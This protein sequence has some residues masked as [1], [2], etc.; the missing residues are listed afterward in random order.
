MNDT[1]FIICC[2]LTH[3]DPPYPSCEPSHEDQQ[4]KVRLVNSAPGL[5]SLSKQ[6]SDLEHL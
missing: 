1:T 2:P 5:Q 3:Q 4:Q 6:F